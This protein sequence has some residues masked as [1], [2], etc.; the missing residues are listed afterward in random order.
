MREAVQ[1]ELTYAREWLSAAMR[2]VES[3]QDWEYSRGPKRLLNTHNI[4][5]ALESITDSIMLL[6]RLEAKVAGS[7]FKPNL[8]SWEV[9]YEDVRTYRRLLFPWLSYVALRSHAEL[10]HTYSA[11][12]LRELTLRLGELARCGLDWE[13]RARI[14]RSIDPSPWANRPLGQDEG[15][16]Y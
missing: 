10:L 7:D 15:G 3:E 4:E 9:L 8:D 11:E 13:A 2:I 14:V 1:S 12:W 6:E 16:I 5:G